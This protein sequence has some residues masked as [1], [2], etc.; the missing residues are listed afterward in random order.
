MAPSNNPPASPSLLGQI[1]R[2]GS[3]LLL[4]I[5]EQ[6]LL[7]YSAFR[8]TLRGECDATELRQGLLR[9][10]LGS[11]PVFVATAVFVG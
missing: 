8:A 7:L 9:L 3:D 1:T 10:G 6:F 11:V 5:G 4:R 2:I